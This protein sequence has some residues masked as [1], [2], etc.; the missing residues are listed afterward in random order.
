MGAYRSASRSLRGRWEAVGVEEPEVGGREGGK[1]EGT[2][3]GLEN[4]FHSPFAVTHLNHA[5]A[6]VDWRKSVQPPEDVVQKF[7]DLVDLV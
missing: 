6:T 5:T 3:V 4:I 1:G 2:K 7:A